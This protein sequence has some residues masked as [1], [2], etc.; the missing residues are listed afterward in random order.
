MPKLKEGTILPTPAEDK[1]ITTAAL[2]D[3]D[4]LPL[5]EAEWAEVQPTV[6]VGRP[7][8]IAPKQRITIRLSPDVVHQFRATGAGWQTRIDI[9]LRQWLQEHPL[10]PPTTTT[11]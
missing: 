1:H 6:R 3:P 2:A 5:T 9:A 11:D 4:A 10:P 8:S 7:R